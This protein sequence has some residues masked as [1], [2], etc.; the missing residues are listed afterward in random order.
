MSRTLTAAVALCVAAISSIALADPATPTATAPA[1]P[2]DAAAP[3]KPAA[4]ALDPDRKICK[5]VLPTGSR[6]GGT[7]TCM[8]KSQWDAQSAADRAQ[9]QQST[10]YRAAPAPDT[11]RRRQITADRS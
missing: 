2:A 1:A 3:A 9:F 11:E 4:K 10:S 5:T 8:T 6:L 7:T